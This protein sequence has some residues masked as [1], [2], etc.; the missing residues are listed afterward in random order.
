MQL[1]FL[2]RMTQDLVNSL[3]FTLPTAIEGLGFLTPKVCLGKET[4]SL[5]KKYFWESTSDMLYQQLNCVLYLMLHFKYC[6]FNK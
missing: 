6:N 5:G 3:V 1:S 2:L 4:P